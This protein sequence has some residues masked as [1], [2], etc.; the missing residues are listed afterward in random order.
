[1]LKFSLFISAYRWA[2]QVSFDFSELLRLLSILLLPIK[3]YASR[4]NNYYYPSG[5]CPCNWYTWI[6]KYK[7]LL[8]C[9]ESGRIYFKICLITPCYFPVMFNFIET[10]VFLAFGTM[11]KASKS[12][13]TPLPTILTLRNTRV[14][15]DSS[16]SSDI[17]TYIET[18]VN[19]TFSF[20]TILKIPNIDL[21]NSHV[22]F[23]RHLN[24]M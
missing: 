24:D 11:C 7:V 3:T 22:R 16:N 18:S 13:T 23:R 14:H 5:V 19:N 2:N 20:C 15:I 8:F 1:M 6:N 10:I 4:M 12:S 9:F 21:N 17:M